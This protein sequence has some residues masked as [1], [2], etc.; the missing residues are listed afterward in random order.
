MKNIF[1][2]LFS[3]VLIILIVVAFKNKD[4]LNN[5]IVK[6]PTGDSLNIT[7]DNSKTM[8]KK[9]IVLHCKAPA[10]IQKYT[11]SFPELADININDLFL[12]PRMFKQNNHIKDRQ[13]KII[14]RY[15]PANHLLY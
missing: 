7:K 15:L 4:V 3:I 13:Y 1:V 12:L 14:H 2:W 9:L 5:L 6:L 11:I 8:Y 10:S